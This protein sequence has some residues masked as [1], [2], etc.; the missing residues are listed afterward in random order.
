GLI[1]YKVID[2]YAF[3]YGDPLC[4]E[5]NRLQLMQAFFQFAIEKD[6]KNI[7]T[8]I[9]SKEYTQWAYLQGMTRAAIEFGYEL[10]IDPHDDPRAHT[11]THA[12]LVRRKMRHALK[13]GVE[14]QEYTSPDPTVEAALEKV[15]TAWL[16]GRKGAQIHISHLDLFNHRLGKRWFYAQQKER[17]VGMVMLS[18]L[19]SKQGWLI[20]HLIFV[21]DA[22]HGTPEILLLTVLDVL[23][24]EGCHFATFGAVPANQLGELVGFKPFSRCF[25]PLVYRTINRMFHLGGKLKFWEKFHPEQKPCLITFS[26]DSISPRAI[27]ALMRALNVF[28]G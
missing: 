25:L 12:S 1:G 28:S 20:H 22:P 24:K 26:N 23:S 4:K 2:R 6:L 19:E 14:I 18:R 9:A 10:F 5:E 17:F 13:E 3:L 27:L 11:G 16:Q 7:I 21:P 8:L 15:K